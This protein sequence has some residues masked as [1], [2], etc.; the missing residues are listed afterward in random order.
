M[1]LHYIHIIVL[2]D[3]SELVTVLKEGRQVLS[4]FKYLCGIF[5]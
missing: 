4:G 5:V 3:L 2:W 1:N